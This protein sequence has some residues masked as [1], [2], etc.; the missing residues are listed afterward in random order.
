MPGNYLF[1]REAFRRRFYFISAENSASSGTTF[2]RRILPASRSR[3]PGSNGIEEMSRSVHF[4]DPFKRF[5]RFLIT[6][7]TAPTDGHPGRFLDRRPALMARATRGAIFDLS[8][9]P[10]VRRR[11]IS[12]PRER[13]NGNDLAC[14][15]RALIRIGRCPDNGYNICR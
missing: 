1:G 11:T 3:R 10:R 6:L 9:G 15:I 13:F 4:P 2:R 5:D 7:N 14:I 12:K 8:F